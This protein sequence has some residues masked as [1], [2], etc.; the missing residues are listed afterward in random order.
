MY[1]ESCEIINNKYCHNIGDKY[2]FED[3]TLLV[4][5][6]GCGK[7]TL[8][9]MLRDNVDLKV[10]LTALGIQG[11]NTFYFDFEKDNPRIKDPQLFTNPSGTNKGIGYAKAISVRFQSH[12]EALKEFSIEPLKKAKDCVV[13][14]DEPE[15]ALSLRN[16]FLLIKT[17]KE[18]V[19]RKCQFI[20]AT[21]CLPLISSVDTVLS[22]EDDR[23]LTSK[24]FIQK[25]KNES[26]D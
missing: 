15:S 3:I 18:A 19:Q 11:V 8:L 9:S 4:G 13:F 5:D 24:E 6:Q 26:Q 20:I 25:N 1:V 22:L 16:Q 2:T 14:L 12:G 17:I 23:W 10:N 21:H 7:S